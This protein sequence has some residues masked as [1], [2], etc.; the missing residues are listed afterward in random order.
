ML[1][2][3]RCRVYAHTESTSMKSLQSCSLHPCRVYIHAESTPMQSLHLCRVYNHVGSTPL[4]SL[5]RCR[6]CTN[7]ESTPM[8]GLHLCSLQ[9]CRVCTHAE[10][11]R[12]PYEQR[13]SWWLRMTFLSRPLVSV[14]VLCT[15]GVGGQG[16]CSLGR[17]QG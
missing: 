12:H 13:T 10:S 7:A 9:P 17:E 4:Q 8:Q 6:V 5:P 14:V 3:D 2:P 16:G 11:I 15:A 1:C